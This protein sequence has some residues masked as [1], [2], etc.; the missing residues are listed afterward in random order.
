M[1]PTEIVETADAV[2]RDNGIHATRQYTCGSPTRKSASLDVEL[3]DISK[4]DSV[5]VGE[6]LS[7]GIVIRAVMPWGHRKHQHPTAYIVQE[8]GDECDHWTRVWFGEVKT[9]VSLA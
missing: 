7:E 8:L 4:L 9:E 6:L 1:I 2:L 5:T 3:D